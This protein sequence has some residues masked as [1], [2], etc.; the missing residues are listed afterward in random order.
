[1][2]TSIKKIV[3]YLSVTCVLLIV[4]E[5]C[6]YRTHTGSTRPHLSHLESS[7]SL[8]YTQLLRN[9]TS[10]ETSSPPVT[11]NIDRQT[12]DVITDDEEFSDAREKSPARLPISV[13]RNNSFKIKNPRPEVG[14]TRDN[15]ARNKT[16][17]SPAVDLLET[18]LEEERRLRQS[19]FIRFQDFTENTSSS[20]DVSTSVK[21]ISYFRPD[22]STTFL[23]K[24]FSICQYKCRYVRNMSRADAVLFQASLIRD[25]VIPDFYRP[26]GQ[27]WVFFTSDPAIKQYELERPD[28]KS[29]FNWTVTYQ[30]D[31]DFP[32]PFGYLQKRKPPVRNYDTVFDRK[33]K[34]AA[35]FVSHCSTWG[36]RELY[37]QRMRKIIQVDI[38]GQC[39]N[40]SCG[41]IHYRMNDSTQCLPMLTQQYKFYLAFE[42]SFCKDYVSEKFFKL[43]DNVDVVPVVRGG[44]DYKKYLPS[45]IFVDAS[46][47]KSPEALA[48]HLLQLARDK[49]KYVAMLKK[50]SQ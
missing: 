25:N 5:E 38:F 1:M 17:T 21:L 3:V 6:F 43:F 12:A 11:Y 19:P 9:S 50:K 33:N 47:F 46:D 42:N 30:L 22:D 13:Q 15:T 27:R 40:L 37:V 45:G 34:M 24:S 14:E 18:E 31:S 29:Q 41:P 36:K 8:T 16:V 39:G 4:V 35:W 49:E 26:P 2:L 23:P 10:L 48:H 20:S 32:S 7:R 44:F 28:V